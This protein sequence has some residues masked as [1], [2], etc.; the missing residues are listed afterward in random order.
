MANAQN[1][2]KPENNT[3]SAVKPI[4]AANDSP[5]TAHLREPED[6]YLTGGQRN[7]QR[8][9]LGLN[10]DGMKSPLNPQPKLSS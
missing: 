6:A 3:A 7:L 1:R 9:V 2:T 5:T 8:R 10:I 4:T